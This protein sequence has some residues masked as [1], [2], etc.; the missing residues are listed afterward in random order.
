V[1]GASGTVEKFLAQDE[2]RYKRLDDDHF[3]ILFE[4][5]NMDTIA[6]YIFCSRDFVRFS[7]PLT[8]PI[9]KGCVEAYERLLKWCLEMNFA[10]FSLDPYGTPL[11]QI[12]WPWASMNRDEFRTAIA[13][14]LHFA[15][16]Y[17]PE[18]M[19]VIA[20]ESLPG[21]SAVA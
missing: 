1:T 6:I 11:L 2:M 7:T 10:K 21:S 20:R 12:E 13:S 18:L 3:R 19:E 9:E 8:L 16:K 4:G 14:L 17:Y 15:D 5:K